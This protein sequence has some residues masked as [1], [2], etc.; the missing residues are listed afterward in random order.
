MMSGE[1]TPSQMGGLLMGLRVRGETVDEIT[2]AVTTMRAKMLGV[3]RRPTPSTW[4]APAATPP[5]RSTSPLAPPSSWQAPACRSPNT[6]TGRCRRD[7][8]PPTCCRRSASK[9]ICPPR[10]VGALHRGRRHRLHVRPE[11]SPRDEACRRR[12]AWSSAPARSSICSVRCPIRPASSGRCSASSPNMVEPMAQVLANLGSERV[13]VVHGS[14]GLDEIT[15]SGPTSVAALEDG[16]VRTF[17]ITPEDVG[18]AARQAR[19]AER[20]RCAT[21]MPSALRRPEGQAR[22]YRD[23][24]RPQCG[25]GADRRRQGQGP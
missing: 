6:A 1:A 25:R 14:D 16:D 21:I 24:V 23:I 5:A 18:L 20:R 12:R 13:W 8:A 19:G 11:P 22:A 7:P 17:E 3:T 4:S 2:G 9:S 10:Q 15:I